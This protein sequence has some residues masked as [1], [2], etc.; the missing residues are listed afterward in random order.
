MHTTTHMLLVLAVAVLISGGSGID[1]TNDRISV[2][3]LSTGVLS[4]VKAVTESG[5]IA[6]QIAGDSWA[7]QVAPVAGAPPT[8]LGPSQ[9]PMSSV[10]SDDTHVFVTYGGGKCGPYRVVV[11]YELQPGWAFVTKTLMIQS[12]HEDVQY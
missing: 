12:E 6:Y 1:L 9:C 8:T 10:A 3:F 2:S 11:T 4:T 5:H 7:A